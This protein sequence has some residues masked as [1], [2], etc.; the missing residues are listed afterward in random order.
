MTRCFIVTLC[1]YCL[2]FI[3][4]WTT[5][6]CYVLELK[7]LDLLLLHTCLFT[8]KFATIVHLYVCTCVCVLRTVLIDTALLENVSTYSVLAT[9]FVGH[10]LF[11]RLF[12]SLNS[13]YV[14]VVINHNKTEFV[15]YNKQITAHR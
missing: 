4:H 1:A 13:R 3:V 15:V 7:A 10:V 6:A 12:H 14:D 5:V 8:T 9:V 2:L 11:V